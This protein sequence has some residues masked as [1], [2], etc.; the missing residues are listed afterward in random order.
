VA[1]PQRT[2]R[3]LAGL[4]LDYV[5]QPGTATCMADE[6]LERVRRG[7]PAARS[8]PLL[9]LLARGAAGSVI[10]DYVGGHLRVTVTPC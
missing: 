3:A 5:A 2:G 6:A 7:V 1:A 8:L 9:A 10:L 4:E